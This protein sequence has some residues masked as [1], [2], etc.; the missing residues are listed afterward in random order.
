MSRVEKKVA[1]GEIAYNGHFVLLL[2]CCQSCLLQMHQTFTKCM[3]EEREIAQ[4]LSCFVNVF[5][6]VVK[7]YLQLSIQLIPFVPEKIHLYLEM[8]IFIIVL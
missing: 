3:L 5:N 4:I 2:Q 8:T 1:K 7:L 6:N